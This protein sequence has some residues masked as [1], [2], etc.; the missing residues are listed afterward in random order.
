MINWISVLEVVM[1]S[2]QGALLEAFGTSVVVAVE[3]K[4]DC[5]SAS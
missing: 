3:E 5:A 4:T 2:L 1:L